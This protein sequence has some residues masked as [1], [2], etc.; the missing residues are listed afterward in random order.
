[1]YS[2]GACPFPYMHDS[3]TASHTKQPD[4][5]RLNVLFMTNILD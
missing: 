4:M 3:A 5:P 2:T 1:M